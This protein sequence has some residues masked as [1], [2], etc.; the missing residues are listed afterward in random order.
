MYP[1]TLQVFS[2]LANFSAHMSEHKTGFG[3][4]PPSGLCPLAIYYYTHRKKYVKKAIFKI[5]FLRLE[6]N[7]LARYYSLREKKTK[8]FGKTMII[9]P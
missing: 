5:Q 9:N 2:L 1:G 6:D 4:S 8:K 7:V 3:V